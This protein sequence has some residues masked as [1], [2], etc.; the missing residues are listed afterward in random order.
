MLSYNQLQTPLAK[1]CDG[2]VKVS[3]DDESTVLYVRIST[4]PTWDDSQHH[5]Q[6]QLNALSTLH[7]STK[8]NQLPSTYSITPHTSLHP[9]SYPNKETK[10]QK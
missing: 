10:N 8:P 3:A 6:A 5:T 9:H 1:P 2:T 7:N 4:L